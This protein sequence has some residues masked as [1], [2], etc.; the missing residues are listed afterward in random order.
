MAGS[1]C[2]VGREAHRPPVPALVE[3]T[4]VNR[5][6][7]GLAFGAAQ[8]LLCAQREDSGRA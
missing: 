1:A 3:R 7:V 2:L 5:D 8:Q 4:P 6:G